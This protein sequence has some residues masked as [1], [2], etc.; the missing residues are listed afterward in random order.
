MKGSSSMAGSSRGGMQQQ[1][2]LQ[3]RLWLLRGMCIQ[4][5]VSVYRGFMYDLAKP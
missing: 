3:Q 1:K 2:E 5:L 4:G